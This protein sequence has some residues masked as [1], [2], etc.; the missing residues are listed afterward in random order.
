[1]ASWNQAAYEI[2]DVA[3]AIVGALGL[4]LAMEANPLVA[5]C[6]RPPHA[7]YDISLGLLPGRTLRPLRGCYVLGISAARS[8]HRDR[9]T[10]ARRFLAPDLRRP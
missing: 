1:M 4:P 7:V 9:R 8:R 2:L 3:F 10:A 5:K 6:H